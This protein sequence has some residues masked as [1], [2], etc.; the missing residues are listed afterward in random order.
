VPYQLHCCAVLTLD[1]TDD[2]LLGAIEDELEVVAKL[3]ELAGTDEL[4]AGLMN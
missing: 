2:E 3:E 4:I 1:A